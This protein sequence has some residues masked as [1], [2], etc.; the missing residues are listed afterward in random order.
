MKY[1]LLFSLVA[2]S[3]SLQHS[4]ED[5]SY[6]NAKEIYDFFI[7][8]NWTVNAISGMLGNIHW[9]SDGIQPDINEMGGSGYGLVQFT[10]ADKKGLLYDTTVGQG[11]SIG[12]LGLQVEAFDSYI[13]KYVK[14]LYSSL[15][16]PNITPTAAAEGILAK[17][18]IPAKKVWDKTSKER[19]ESSIKWQ[20]ILS[21]NSDATMPGAAASASAPS[22]A[23]QIL[24][25]MLYIM[26]K[27]MEIIIGTASLTIAF[28]GSPVIIS[29]LLFFSLA[30]LISP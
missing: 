8:Q 18:E 30:N 9:E 15:H 6:E 5:P 13:Q 27:S 21:G 19:R 28:L 22:P 23:T 17:Y 12:D 2:L 26:I 29:I 25:A 10:S 20:Q 14:G 4:K 7:A 11:K 24:S 1:F 3:F 16:D